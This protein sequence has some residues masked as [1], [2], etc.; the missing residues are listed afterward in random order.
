[1]IAFVKRYLLITFFPIS[2]GS[3][4]LGAALLTYLPEAV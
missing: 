2:I 4:Y 1:V 3:F